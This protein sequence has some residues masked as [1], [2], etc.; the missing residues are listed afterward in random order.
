MMLEQKLIDALIE[1]LDFI[2]NRIEADCTYMNANGLM[3]DNPL[4]VIKNKI[5]Q[6]ATTPAPHQSNINFNEFQGWL[7]GYLSQKINDTVDEL[8]EDINDAVSEKIKKMLE[9]EA[10]KNHALQVKNG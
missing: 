8:V 7:D 6:L 4:A 5:K 2:E 3:R 1:L 10:R 9:D